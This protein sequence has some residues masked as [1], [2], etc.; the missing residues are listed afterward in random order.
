LLLYKCNVEGIKFIASY[1]VRLCL[2]MLTYS[3]RLS[4]YFK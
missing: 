3:M 2:P 1:G 4:F